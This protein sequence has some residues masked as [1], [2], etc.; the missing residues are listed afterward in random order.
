MKNIMR[1][2]LGLLLVF[3]LAATCAADQQTTVLSTDVRYKEVR[4]TLPYIDGSNSQALEKQ[5]NNLIREAARL[6]AEKTG[7]GSL[8]YEVALNRPSLLGLLLKAEGSRGTFYKALNLDLTSGKELTIGDFFMNEEG[9]NSLL[10]GSKGFLYSEEGLLLAAQA[11]G[12]YVQLL[13]Y[14]S[15]LRYLRIGEAGR[16]LQIARLTRECE[17][18]TLHLTKGGLIAFK[19]DANPSTGYGWTFTA[20]KGV[21]KVGSSFVMPPAGDTRVGTP[22]TEI[23]FL[24]VTGAGRHVIDMAYKRPWETYIADRFQLTV[25]VG[26]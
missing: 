21:S 6:L 18:K 11:D 17:G 24:A 4:G 14:S 23:I 9:L 19:L 1:L 15:L 12:P 22:G 16:I 2:L 10:A 25:E 13:P 20:D 3:S 26:A 8:S 7:S 5:A